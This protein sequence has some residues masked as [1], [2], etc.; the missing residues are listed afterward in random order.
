MKTL[1]LLL[2]VAGLL[3]GPGYWIY[4]RFFTGSRVAMLDLT[5]EAAADWRSPVFDLSADMAAVGLILHV[6]TH[7]APVEEGRVRQNRCLATLHRD[8][9]AAKPLAFTL[10]S[11]HAVEPDPSFREH[12]LFMQEVRPGRYWLEIEPSAPA[13]MTLGKL[14]LE[15]RRNLA[16]PDSRVVT[17]GLVLFVIGLVGLV[18]I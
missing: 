13:D 3:A 5:H 18:A 8:N 9:E 16:E 1:A 6:Q 10:R 15:V 17:T 14:R 2:L 7:S 11:T 4:A 12:L